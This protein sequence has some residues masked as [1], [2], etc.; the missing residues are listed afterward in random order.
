MYLDRH[1]NQR[2]TG[3]MMCRSSRLYKSMDL[4]RKR[5]DS[6]IWKGTH[7]SNSQTKSVSFDVTRFFLW[8]FILLLLSFALSDWLM[9]VTY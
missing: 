8:A 3:T 7:S 4:Y 1:K 6:W 5:R 9:W 2:W